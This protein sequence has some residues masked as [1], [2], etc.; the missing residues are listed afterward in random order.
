MVKSL[1]CP[2]CGSANERPALSSWPIDIQS[3]LERSVTQF[4]SVGL[5]RNPHLT[6]NLASQTFLDDLAS[7]LFEYRPHIL[8]FLLLLTGLLYTRVLAARVRIGILHNL[9][10]SSSLGYFS[11]WCAQATIRTPWPNAC[12]QALHKCVCVHKSIA[13]RVC[14]YKTAQSPQD[15]RNIV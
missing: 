3:Q 5:C 7:S 6:V 8:S 2:M 4:F 10:T 9:S 1:V 11:S 12:E 15:A 14:V 13:A